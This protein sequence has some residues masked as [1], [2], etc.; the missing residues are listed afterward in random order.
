MGRRIW[1]QKLNEAKF[2][3]IGE[4][5]VEDKRL[6]RTRGRRDSIK[7]RNKEDMKRSKSIEIVGRGKPVME[8]SESGTKL[9]Y[10]LQSQHLSLRGKLANKKNMKNISSGALSDGETIIS[11]GKH[12]TRLKA[13]DSIR[14]AR[15]NILPLKAITRSNDAL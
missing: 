11:S 7:V 8:K 10:K 3:H 12:R 1:L 14:K 5:Q 2:Q 9:N 6:K 13:R 4:K 15:A